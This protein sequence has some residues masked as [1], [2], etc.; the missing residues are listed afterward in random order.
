MYFYWYSCFSHSV[1][2][3]TL[4]SLKSFYSLSRSL[5]YSIYRAVWEFTVSVSTQPI[6]HKVP[7]PRVCAL[8]FVFPTKSFITSDLIYNQTVIDV[9]A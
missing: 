3:F 6:S 2:E 9:T 4:K 7:V 1:N 5:L 8:R